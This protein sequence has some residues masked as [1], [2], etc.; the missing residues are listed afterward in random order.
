[1]R[2]IWL[3]GEHLSVSNFHSFR[4]KSST[5]T[6]L[7]HLFN[8][9][10]TDK[11]GILYIEIPNTQ[12]FTLKDF[13][14][15]PDGIGSQVLFPN[16][17]TE[18]PTITIPKEKVLFSIY[19]R[20]QLLE[21]FFQSQYD[22]FFQDCCFYCGRSLCYN[23]HHELKFI[24]IWNRTEWFFLTPNIVFSEKFQTSVVGFEDYEVMFM[25]EYKDKVSCVTALNV[26]TE[27]LEDWWVI[28]SKIL[29]KVFENHQKHFISLGS[30][31]LYA[32]WKHGISW[33]EHIL[34]VFKGNLMK[35]FFPILNFTK[36]IEMFG[37]QTKSQLSMD[38]D[39][40]RLVMQG[41]NLF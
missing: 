40:Q 34:D 24:E 12:R 19:G 39:T 4:I 31:C 7:N 41:S 3:E 26:T 2:I 33:T 37:N 5:V 13:H 28:D 38:R 20:R 6:F 23:Y 8:N 9:N 35:I 25:V 29:T 30:I 27:T 14:L 32:M 11:L 17:I 10:I 22:A 15:R 21:T 36:E 18:I 16:N 1:M